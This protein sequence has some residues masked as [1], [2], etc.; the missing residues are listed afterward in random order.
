MASHRDAI[1]VVRYA[2]SIATRDGA[3]SRYMR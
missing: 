2:A 3:V 1:M